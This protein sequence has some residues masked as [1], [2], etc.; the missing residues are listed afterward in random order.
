M[1]TFNSPARVAILTTD[2]TIFTAT[3]D[4]TMVLASIISNVDG[5]VSCDVDCWWVDASDGNVAGYFCKGTPIPAKAAY[6]P[7][8]SK[9]ILM[10]GDSIRAKATAAGDL[11]MSVSITVL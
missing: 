8:P 7:V 2:T 6:E 11:E 1:P 9:F 10:N 5:S 4:N 3:A